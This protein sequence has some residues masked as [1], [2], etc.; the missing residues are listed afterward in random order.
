[1][2]DI[3]KPQND[4]HV[5]EKKY[6]PGKGGKDFIVDPPMEQEMLTNKVLNANA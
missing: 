3:K 2:P 6:F 5:H 4:V 1:M